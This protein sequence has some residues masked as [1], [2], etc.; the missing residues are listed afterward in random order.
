VPTHHHDLDRRQHRRFDAAIQVRPLSSPTQAPPRRVRDVSLGGLRAYTDEP[1]LGGARL[2]LELLFQDT[3]YARVLAEVVWLEPL[4]D[5]APARY[6]VGLRY[7]DQANRDRA[8]PG[9]AAE[10]ARAASLATTMTWPT[11]TPVP[12]HKVP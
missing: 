9:R 11:R 4:P 12:L 6:H 3:V 2:E 5:D 10:P 1:F 7:I 8:R